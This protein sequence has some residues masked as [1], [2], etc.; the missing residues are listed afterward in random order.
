MEKNII[1]LKV[2]DDDEI[3]G[4]YAVALVEA[5]A[6]EVDFY[7]FEEEEFETYND[8][9]EGA[10]SN[11][12]RAIEWAEKN[13]W[14]SCGTDVGKQRAHQL[15]NGENISEE[16]IARMAAFERHRKNS[17]TPY[18][19]GCGKLMWDAWGGDAGIRWAQNKLEKIRAEKF[20]DPRP[21]ESEN[22]YIGRCI[23]H[24]MTKEGYDKEQAAAICYSTWEDMA[25]DTSGLSPY[26]Q[27]TK[28]KKK[29]NFDYQTINEEIEDVVLEYAKQAGFTKTQITEHF[30]NAGAG[31][32]S[33]L[34][35]ELLPGLEDGKEGQI[36]LYKYSGALRSTSRSFCRQM[37]ALDKYYTFQDIE[38]MSMMAVNAGFGPSGTNTYDIWLY[39]G[40][41]RC[42]HYWTR[43]FAKYKDG[44]FSL[45]SRG[46][47]SGRP[48]T[49]TNDMANHGYILEKQFFMDEDEKI[50]IGPAMIPDIEIPRKDK[51]GDIY[52]VKFSKDT[53]FTIQ[54]KFMKTQSTHSTN[55]DHNENKPADTYIFESWI[56]EDEKKDKSFLYGFDLPIG[57]WFVKMRV[58]NQKVWERIKKG[59]LRGLSVEG[60]FIS[61]RDK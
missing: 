8:Y 36:T 14:G 18:S 4:V 59:E 48:G 26:I 37:I 42:H 50:L 38:A 49:I 19:E 25:I 10:R 34:P 15:C 16:T 57:T 61:S 45:Q 41:A 46:R 30:A 43:Y 40:G 21:T 1:E 31:G 11:A 28:K 20:V 2:F 32:G 29:Y 47:V 3:S 53:I 5:P 35:D 24:L 27:N 52:F 6:I 54:E 23:E 9:P 22:E 56:K 51:N 33:R 58:D 60:E 39:K 55:Q 44:L 7:A 12:C 17:D 13:G